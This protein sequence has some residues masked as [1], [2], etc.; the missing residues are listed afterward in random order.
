VALSPRLAPLDRWTLAYATLAFAITL[1]RWPWS[2]GWPLGLL[3][4]PVLLAVGAGMAP[5]GRVR[6]GV[7]RFL[8]EFYPLFA[9]IALYSVIGVLNRA[10]GVSYDARV[11]A[12][13]RALFGTQPALVWMEA[14]PWPVL[15]W[16]LHAGYLSY[17]AIVA[18]APL[19]Q[20][21]SGRREGALRTALATSIAFYVC[22][23]AFL[24]FPVAG[25]RYVFPPAA[26]AATAVLPARLAHEL[27]EGAAAWGTA[28]PSSHVAAA[29]AASVSAAQGWPALGAVL[30]PLSVLLA[31]GTV[32]GRFHYA[33]DALAGVAVALMALLC[34]RGAAGNITR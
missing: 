29:F 30:V 33:V 8:A 22:Y 25:P 26:N 14:W 28:F 10:V 31:L 9:A 6:G 20:W 13:E 16:A 21:V 32:Y 34:A 27:L 11:Q 2:Q 24:V 1:L 23:A 3:A 7:V 19:A 4:V 17:Y 5:R 18:A 12:W 15:S